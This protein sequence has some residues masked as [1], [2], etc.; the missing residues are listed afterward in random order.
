MNKTRVKC[1][2]CSARFFLIDLKPCP[3]CKTA[4]SVKK[5]RKLNIDEIVGVAPEEEE[6]ED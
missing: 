4:Y 2:H 6:E 3:H 1:S 5:G